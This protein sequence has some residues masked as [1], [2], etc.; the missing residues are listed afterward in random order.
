[1]GKKTGRGERAVNV[2]GRFQKVC[3]DHDGATSKR[4]RRFRDLGTRG[5]HSPGLQVHVG[6][7]EIY[8]RY[9]GSKCKKRGEGMTKKK[10]AYD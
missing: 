8:L 7:K 6:G 2:W 3:N 4:K 5:M 1:M 9:L 10:I